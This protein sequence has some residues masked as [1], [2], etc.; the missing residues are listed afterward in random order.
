MWAEDPSLLFVL[1]LDVA[2]LVLAAHQGLT[3]QQDAALPHDV[4]TF[5]VLLLVVR[6]AFDTVQVISI[7][8]LV[9]SFLHVVL[10][11]AVI[12]VLFGFF[13]A[14]SHLII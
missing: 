5:E 10:V 14:Y 9:D 2:L 7:R 11:Q 1:W 13:E 3:R 8:G 4:H 6:N 12:L